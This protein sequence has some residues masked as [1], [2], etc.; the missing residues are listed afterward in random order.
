MLGRRR[1]R[2]RRGR[3]VDIVAIP[4]A[5]APAPECCD[6]G[7]GGLCCPCVRRRRFGRGRLGPPRRLR[8]GE[9][10]QTGS[11]GRRRAGFVMV[12]VCVSIRRRHR[13]C[14]C[15]C[16][17][18]EPPRDIAGDRR[19]AVGGPPRGA[20]GG[21]EARRGG[22]GGARQELTLEELDRCRRRG[23]RGERPAERVGEG[24]RGVRLFCFQPGDKKEL[25]F[26][27][28]L[29]F[30]RKAEKAR[31]RKRELSSLY[32]RFEI[33][34]RTFTSSRARSRACRMLAIM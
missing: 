15:R 8:R 9:L 16:C 31:R 32:A 6:G 12:A 33:N 10:E 20:C 22:G 28:L 30:C 7:G 11:R 1:G 25:F 21:R 18:L 27:E 5:A 23:R 4:F 3:L 13:C 29:F 34:A 19:G 2:G 17:F 24:G 14:C 26:L